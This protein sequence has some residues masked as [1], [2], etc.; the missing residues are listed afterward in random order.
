MSQS[1]NEPKETSNVAGGNAE[2]DETDLQHGWK[3]S[4]TEN[5]GEIVNHV[6]A[7]YGGEYYWGLGGDGDFVYDAESW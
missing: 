7:V 6:D 4:I 3:E 5:A 1:T 2:V